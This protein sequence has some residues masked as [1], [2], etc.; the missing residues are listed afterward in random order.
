MN[1][2]NHTP[3]NIIKGLFV[4]PEGE[5]LTLD[6]WPSRR[7]TLTLDAN[8][9]NDIPQIAAEDNEK[10]DSNFMKK[11]VKEAIF[12][13]KVNK[14]LGLDGFPAEFYQIFRDII[15]GDLMALFKDFDEGKFPLFN[16]NFGIITLLPRQ[17]EVTHIKQYHTICLLN[18]SF[19]IFTKVIVNRITGIADQIMSPSQT[20]FILDRNIMEGVVMLHETIHEVHRKKMNYVTLKLDFDKAYDKVNW[21]FL[22]QTLRMKASSYKCCLWIKQFTIKGSVGIKVNDNIGRYFQMKKGL[23]QGDPYHLCSLT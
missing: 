17:K 12:Q 13:M 9:R 15:K 5:T 19:K 4:P 2:W 16:L 10:L 21:E 22:Q 3:H 14:S 11:E 20:R 8:R 7:E 1:I 18:V 6:V 23:R